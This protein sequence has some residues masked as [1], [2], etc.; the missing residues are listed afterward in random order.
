MTSMN[1]QDMHPQTKKNAR[2]Q[3]NVCDCFVGHLLIVI[4][5][6]LIFPYLPQR[7]R[8]SVGSARCHGLRDWRWCDKC[9]PHASWHPRREPGPWQ[10]KYL[11]ASGFV[12]S[13]YMTSQPSEV[14]KQS[15]KHVCGKAF[16]LV[17]L[18]RSLAIVRLPK[19]KKM[20]D[21]IV[22][23]NY[24]KLLQIVDRQSL[25]LNIYLEVHPLT[26]GD[27]WFPCQLAPFDFWVMN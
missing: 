14:I 19:G 24:G 17:L 15:I 3:R 10:R 5:S 16:L 22:L 13:W 21:F 6:S 2:K 27:R 8:V 11:R 4:E 9:A 18:A 7:P 20:N 25:Q 1:I 12:R 23:V 26:G